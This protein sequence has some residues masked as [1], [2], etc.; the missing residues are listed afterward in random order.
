M[1]KRRRLMLRNAPSAL[2]DNDLW[3]AVE[4]GEGH[5]SAEEWR[6][7]YPFWNDTVRDALL[8][9]AADLG[10]FF[11]VKRMIEELGRVESRRGYALSA[12]TLE[13][14]LRPAIED[15]V[16]RG[17][18]ERTDYIAERIGLPRGSV[19]YRIT[20]VG[21]EAALA[22]RVLSHTGEDAIEDAIAD[23][24]ARAEA[25]EAD[26]DFG[27]NAPEAP[28]APPALDRENLEAFA[29]AIV[30]AART[31]Q[32][33]WFGDNK[34]FLSH[35][36]Q[37]YRRVWGPIKDV[38]AKRWLLE[39]NGAGLLELARADLVEAMDPRD[40]AASETAI[41]DLAR[42]HLLVVPPLEAPAPAPEAPRAVR[43]ERRYTPAETP[44]SLRPQEW[45]P[46][47]REAY[48]VLTS[49]AATAMDARE[50]FGEH[51]DEYR[52]AYK[53][54]RIARKHWLAAFHP[55]KWSHLDPNKPAPASR[56]STSASTPVA[57]TPAAR[58]RK[59]KTAAKRCGVPG[60]PR[61]VEPHPPATKRGCHLCGIRHRA[62][63]HRSHVV[64]GKETC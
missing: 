58:H 22:A 18:L 55:E 59:R 60:R 27:A 32:T 8:Q 49:A 52:A 2:E 17:Y 1:T 44:D 9:T 3:L 7:R 45:T 21:R 35:A 13:T 25:G 36:I 12:A 57:S 19:V 53:V 26:F 5:N 30:T 29:K 62:R 43:A 6:A 11:T 16:S 20:D 28:A 56:P 54:S 4:R 14:R 23:E 37:A 33:G 31:S 41:G 63:E 42:F 50:R 24:I 61:M 40:V 64:A 48:L 51:S 34:V 10:S 47:Q 46:E 39:A 15:L 38:D